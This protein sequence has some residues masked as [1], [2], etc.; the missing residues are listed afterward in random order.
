MGGKLTIQTKGSKFGKFQE[1]KIQ[2]EADQVPKNNTNDPQH[3]LFSPY[4][5]TPFLPYVKR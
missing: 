4:V 5:A 2:E 3:R 1:V